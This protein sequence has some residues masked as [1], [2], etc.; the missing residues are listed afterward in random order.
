MKTDSAM[1]NSSFNLLPGQ[2]M[3]F[4]GWVRQDC[5]TPCFITNYTHPTVSLRFPGATPS[6]IPLHAKGPII[7][8]W[9]RVDTF[10]TVPAGATAARL[11]LGS[12]TTLKTYFDDIRIHPFNADMKTYVYDPQS[13]RL[14][15]EMD[16]NN[17]A[18]F[19]NYDEE[20]QLVRVK[21]ETIQGV[22]TIKETRTAKQ[23]N[24][25]NVQ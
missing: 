9:Q 6:S 12:D 19:Y 15:A 10:F 1:F 4:S 14:I 3:Q 8:G 17:Y 7:E 25:T 13:L 11:L 24:I 22:K 5:G 16:E 21:K 2:K 20:G 23:K 18:T